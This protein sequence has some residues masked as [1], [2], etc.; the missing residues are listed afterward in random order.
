MFFKPSGNIKR[1]P[2]IKP[3]IFATPQNIYET[4]HNTAS[5]MDIG[6]L[7]QLSYWPI[8]GKADFSTLPIIHTRFIVAIHSTYTQHSLPFF[9]S[10]ARI[11]DFHPFSFGKNKHWV[12][13]RFENF[14]MFRKQL[15]HPSDTLQKRLLVQHL[16]SPRAT[17]Q[18]L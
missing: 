10:Y 6:A 8:L 1:A 15:R 17:E 2:D 12:H 11:Q 9:Q 14:R 5:P 16:P 18:R 3:S 13:I 4:F 7:Y